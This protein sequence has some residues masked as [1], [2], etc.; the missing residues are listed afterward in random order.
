VIVV[1]CIG[2]EGNLEMYTRGVTSAPA[3]EGG[4]SR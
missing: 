2:W 4:M 3:V 1:A